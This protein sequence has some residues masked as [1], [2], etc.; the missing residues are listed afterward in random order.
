MQRSHAMVA[1]FATVLVFGPT[2][3]S[4]AQPD[5]DQ[6]QPVQPG[7]E[8]GLGLMGPEVPQALKDAQSN[9]YGLPT[10]V[11]CATLSQHIADLDRALGPDLDSPQMEAKKDKT[12]DLMS[13]VRAV[14]PYGGVVRTLTGAGK[15]EQALVNAALASW[16]RRGYLKGLAHSRGCQVSG[17][18]TPAAAVV[19]VSQPTTTQTSATTSTTKKKKKKQ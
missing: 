2:L 11:N 10:P 16:E 12:E 19:R 14:L 1:A 13:G 9:P 5:Q 18:S 6:Q 17:A 8:Q 4:H 7:K 15:K 3:A